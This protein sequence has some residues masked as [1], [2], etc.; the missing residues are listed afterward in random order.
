MISGLDGMRAIAFLLVLGAH[1]DILSF[2]W[3]GLQLFFVLSGF[4]ITGILL[5]MK[6]SL[7]KREYF[8]KFYG[9]RFLR[10]VPLYYFYLFLLF[11]VNFMA[12]NMGFKP[13]INEF[14]GKFWTQ[15]WPSVFYIYDFFHTTIAFEHS[16][17]FTHLWSL[18]VEEQFYILWPLILFLTPKTQLKK[19]F[20]GAIILG[21]LMRGLIYL[22]YTYFRAPFMIDMPDVAVYAMPFSHIDAFAFG[23]YASQFEI[24]RPR[25][26]LI[27]AAILVPAIGL[28]TQY[29]V[30]GQLAWNTLGQ[31][32]LLSVD[33]MNIW[34]YSLLNYLFMVTIYNVA[35][36][37][38]WNTLLDIAPL[39]YLGKI[40]YGLYVYHT[41][42]IWFILK[43]SN[44]IDAGAP[45]LYYFSL[46]VTILVASLS[47][48][49]F[50][51]PINDFKDKFFPLSSHS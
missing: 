41:G 35:K 44:T 36:M 42:V 19:L 7:G 21:P 17:F 27:L 16:R 47:Y 48:F 46:V 34:G 26:Q 39:R 33:H 23:A 10:I 9:R 28:A 6:S 49:L 29:L 4:L 5:R 25:L 8:T 2:G 15:F 1:T 43:F 38:F 14:G 20:T 51:K 45:S 18:S 24:P 40:S 12:P 13:L 11:G 30:E 32:F 50:E 22:I 37:G 31:E 3:V